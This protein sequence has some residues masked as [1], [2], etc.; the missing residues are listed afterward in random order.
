MSSLSRCVLVDQHFLVAVTACC[1]QQAPSAF[2][3]M[4]GPHGGAPSAGPCGADGGALVSHR[5][6]AALRS[7]ERRPALTPW[8]LRPPVRMG[9][10]PGGRPPALHLPVLQGGLLALFSV[11]RSNVISRTLSVPPSCLTQVETL[12]LLSPRGDSRTVR[13]PPL[14]VRRWLSLY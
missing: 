10:C 3:E 6:P 5:S 9:S 2:T 11:C 8:P 14:H 1:R 4:G 12:Y 13:Q 7:P